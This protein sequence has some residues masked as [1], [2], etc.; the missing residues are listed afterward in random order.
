MREQGRWLFAG[1]KYLYLWLSSEDL[2]RDA[3]RLSEEI[4]LASA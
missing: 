2:R 1:R 3:V 4:A